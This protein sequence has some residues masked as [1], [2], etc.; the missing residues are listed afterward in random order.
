MLINGQ[1]SSEELRVAVVNDGVLEEYKVEAAEGDVCR[2]N[3]YRGVVANIEP[4]LNAAFVDFGGEK[5]GFLA[6]QDIVPAAFH[7]KPSSNGKR[8]RVETVL[9][10]GKPVI[11]QVTKDAMGTK[12]AVLTTSVSL[13]GRYLVITPL[14]PAR[15]ISRKLEDESARKALKQ[16]LAALPVP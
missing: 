14:D 15:N 7:R 13:A 6:I 4:A 16:K 11:V 1:R 8:P 5:H 10:K 9:D 2:G 12:G 3:I